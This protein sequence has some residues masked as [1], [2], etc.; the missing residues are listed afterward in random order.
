MNYLDVDK[1]REA[2]FAKFVKVFCVILRLV[3]YGNS[4][5]ELCLSKSVVRIDKNFNNYLQCFNEKRAEPVY[6]L[7]QIPYQKISV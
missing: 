7:C 2:D 5:N 1:N 6:P 3:R 4:A